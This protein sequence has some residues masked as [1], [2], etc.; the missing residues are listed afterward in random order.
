MR[1][2]DEEA[3]DREGRRGARVVQ[4][5]GY[6]LQTGW[7]EARDRVE[8]VVAAMRESGEITDRSLVDGGD[9]PAVRGA[10]A[11]Q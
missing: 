3:P 1:R 2:Y 10:V 5:A 8:R 9:W 11:R 4:L 6:P 7:H